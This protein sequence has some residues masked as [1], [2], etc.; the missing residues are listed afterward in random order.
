M[1]ADG[2]A[3]RPTDVLANER[4]YLAYLRTALAF[5]AFGFVIARFSLFAQEL[6]HLTGRAQPSAHLSSP[7]A[8][9]MAIAGVA[10]GVFGSAR[11]A[12]TDRGLRAG[13]SAAMPPWAAYAGALGI[14]LIGALVA[15]DVLGTG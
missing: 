10:I 2:G 14:A 6:V 13:R 1:A 5:V 15:F 12:V 11:Y 4:T 7:F 8:V 9:A 3:P